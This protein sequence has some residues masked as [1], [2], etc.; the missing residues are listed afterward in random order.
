[1]L[2][3]TKEQLYKI[4]MQRFLNAKTAYF[5]GDEARSV[6]LLKSWWELEMLMALT[7]KFPLPEPPKEPFYYFGSEEPGRKDDPNNQNG[8][9][10]PN[11]PSPVPRKPYPNAG[12]GQSAEPQESS[13]LSE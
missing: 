12:S 2:P 11:D 10:D 5:D 4:S 6:Q 9:N 3:Q 13:A 1:M 8:P 7:Q